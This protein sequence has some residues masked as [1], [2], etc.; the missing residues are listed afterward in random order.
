MANFKYFADVGGE[1]IELTSIT[2]IRNEQFSELFPGVKGRRNDGY[3]KWVGRNPQRTS[4]LLPVTRMIEYK[5]NPS[6]HQCNAKCLGGKANG[7]CECSCGGKNHGAGWG[8]L[9]EALLA[10]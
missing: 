6:L 1:S 7:V 5:R 3:S 4:S 2:T 9:S 10:A 8:S